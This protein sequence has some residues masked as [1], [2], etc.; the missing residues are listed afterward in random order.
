MFSHEGLNGQEILFEL[1]QHKSDEVSSKAEEVLETLFGE[2][3]DDENYLFLEE[4][5]ENDPEM[6]KAIE[7]E[8]EKQPDAP[9]PDVFP[10]GFSAA[11]VA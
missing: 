9:S 5:L 4:R 8:M 10:F 7:A 11:D 6:R 3:F 2:F 1:T